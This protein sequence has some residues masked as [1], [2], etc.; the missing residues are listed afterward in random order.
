MLDK[1]EISQNFSRSAPEYEKHAV[2]QKQLADDLL[3]RLP[4][5]NPTSILDLGCGTGYLTRRLAA[6]FP[7][8][9]VIGIDIAPGMIEEA[10]SRK[11]QQNLKYEVGD[12]EMPFF[13]ENHFDLV[14][15]NASL[16]WMEM[17][18]ALKSVARVMADKGIFAFNTFG[19]RTLY[20]MRESGFRVNDFVP[21]KNIK[22]L[23][24]KDFT[25]EQLESRLVTQSFPG[26]RG[27]LLHLKA[28]GAWGKGKA[29]KNAKDVA[30]AF[31]HYK[32]VFSR[33]DRLLASYE[34][35][36]GILRKR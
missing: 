28:I 15:S 9:E 10:Q 5:L 3:I 32:K 6:L 20:E 31:K 29:A 2:L 34:V 19:A 4:N 36:A 13:A 22:K 35:I 16:Q 8:A 30:A 17:E 14:V 24:A 7:K 1:N 18:K 25:I 11:E 27:L 26:T 23:A 12:G 21:L 33:D